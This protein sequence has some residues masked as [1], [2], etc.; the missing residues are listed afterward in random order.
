VLKKE[1]Y[2]GGADKKCQVRLRGDFVSA[3][4][5]LIRLRE[6]GSWVIQNA[7]EHGTLVNAQRVETRVLTDGDKIQIGTSNVLLFSM[8]EATR[9]AAQR[10]DEASVVSGGAK[11]SVKTLLISAALAIYLAGLV[12]LYF[13]YFK[14]SAGFSGSTFTAASIENSIESSLAYLELQREAP[15]AAQAISAEDPSALYYRLLTADDIGE[16]EIDEFANRLR[17][18]M[19]LALAQLG[20]GQ[21]AIART[22][23]REVYVMAPDIRL[24]STALA[25]STRKALQEE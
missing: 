13:I 22:T 1:S 5:F 14:P 17:K 10:E 18:Q 23:L 12:A 3:E 7:S 9:K 4:H 21:K 2:S 11:V 24:P 8:E 16:A 25:L 20:A 6:D 19:Y 15:L